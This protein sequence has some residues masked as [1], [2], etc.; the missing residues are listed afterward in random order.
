MSWNHFIYKAM[1]QLGVVNNLD[2]ILS[3]HSSVKAITESMSFICSTR[4]WKKQHVG[5]ARTLRTH[6]VTNVVCVQ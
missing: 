2:F 6:L 5:P 3:L 4:M 1:A